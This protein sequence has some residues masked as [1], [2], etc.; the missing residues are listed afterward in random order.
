MQSAPAMRVK[1]HFVDLDVLSPKRLAVHRDDCLVAQLEGREDEA[2]DAYLRVLE[3]DPT[4]ASALVQAARIYYRRGDVSAALP[5]LWEAFG[6][7]PDDP[8]LPVP[9]ECAEQRSEDEDVGR[10]TDHGEY[11]RDDQHGTV[12]EDKTGRWR[13]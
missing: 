1:K 13:T 7:T 5:M 8:Y 4:N 6:Q 9:D 10:E 3:V 12:R 2:L 11:Q